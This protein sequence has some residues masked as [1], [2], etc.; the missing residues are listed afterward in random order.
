MSKASTGQ[1]IWIDEAVVLAVHDRQLVEHGGAAGLARPLNHR[2]YSGVDVIELAA[3]YT[4]GI[5]Q[6][7][8]FVDGNKRTGFVV[9]VLFLELN[10]YRFMASEEAAALAVLELAAGSIDEE[11]FGEFLRSAVTAG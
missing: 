7:H 1:A 6:N 10:G 4:A 3:K 9:G 2:G 8:P 11:G 5:V